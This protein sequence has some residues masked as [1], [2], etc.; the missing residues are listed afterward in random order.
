MGKCPR[1]QNPVCV[2]AS[3]VGQ[4]LR[5]DRW[6]PAGAPTTGVACM[7]MTVSRELDDTGLKKVGWC[8]T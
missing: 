5:F 3:R 7:L 1:G 2:G 6:V 4:P 8:D